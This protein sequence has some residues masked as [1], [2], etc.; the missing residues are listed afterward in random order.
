MLLYLHCNYKAKVI[1][2]IKKPSNMRIEKLELELSKLYIELEQV[3]SMSELQACEYSNTDSK[4]DA[5]E[6]IQ[7][8]IDY[9]EDAIRE[10]ESEYE[11]YSVDLF[12]V[13]LNRCA[14]FV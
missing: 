2:K 11:E 4:S 1:N 9:Y 12:S 5:L 14:L 13:S 7:C 8:E 3:E 10:L 6:A